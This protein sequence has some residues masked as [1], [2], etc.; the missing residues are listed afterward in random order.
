[1]KKISII[2]IIII[3]LPLIVISQDIKLSIS[4]NSGSASG[5]VGGVGGSSGDIIIPSPFGSPSSSGEEG[6]RGGGRDTP[7]TPLENNYD[8]PASEGWG[9]NGMISNDIYDDW[10]GT[11]GWKNYAA[12]VEALSV[13]EEINTLNLSD[14]VDF[15]QLHKVQVKINSLS[16]SEISAL[17]HE[18]K[19]A[20]ARFEEKLIEA[21]SLFSQYLIMAQHIRNNLFSEIDKEVMRLPY[22]E[23]N[24][25]FK[26][27]LSK[28]E[29]DR[30]KIEY[31]KY[32]KAQVVGGVYER[33]RNQEL[34]K[35]HVDRI[36]KTDKTNYH[37]TLQ[38]IRVTAVDN[39]KVGK[40]VVKTFADGQKQLTSTF[41]KEVVPKSELLERVNGAISTVNKATD[42][43][44]IIVKVYSGDLEGACSD[45]KRIAKELVFKPTKDIFNSS[46][47]VLTRKWINIK[48]GIAAY[49]IHSF[50]TE[51]ILRKSLLNVESFG[52]D[53]K[54][55]NANKDL[56]NFLF[57]SIPE[58]TREEIKR[59]Y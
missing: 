6:E 39:Y 56:N 15:K 21:R 49:N 19:E 23:Q 17:G 45:G 42:V 27:F 34:R 8:G 52:D 20:I 57:K 43:K 32:E 3:F 7:S 31:D 5:S 29:F 30:A 1:M 13:L 36:D 35:N 55:Y 9:P 51:G 54:F 44:G 28:E 58:K 25:Y 10:R 48:N 40:M 4:G 41:G 33:I 12:E 38:K 50:S 24:G 26:Q 59:T 14:C 46:V 16:P 18:G 53:K 2:I 47:T 22:E 37:L 11:L